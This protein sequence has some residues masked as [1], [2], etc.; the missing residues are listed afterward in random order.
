MSSYLTTVTPDYNYTLNIAP[1]NELQRDALLT[2][3]KMLTDNNNPLVITISASP[4]FLVHLDW[5]KMTLDDAYVI[6]DLWLDSSK[7]KGSERSFKWYNH[8]DARTYVV[9]FWM[10]GMTSAFA[11]AGQ[12]SLRGISLLVI[13]N[14]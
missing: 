1:Q 7:A 2:Q 4:K 3:V 6:Q 14:A 13:G 5:E 11:P 9:K 10:D 8:S 12:E